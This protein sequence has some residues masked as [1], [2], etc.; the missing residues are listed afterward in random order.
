[1]K[2]IKTSAADSCASPG[3]ISVEQAIE[4]ILEKAEAVEQ[5]EGEVE[6]GGHPVAMGLDIDREVDLLGQPPPALDQRDAILQP[7]WE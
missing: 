3:L 6:V 4:S 5:V 1:M 2:T 7:N